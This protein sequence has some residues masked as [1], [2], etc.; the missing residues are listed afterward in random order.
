MKNKD[1]FDSFEKADAYYNNVCVP[2]FGATRL[3]WGF[4]KWLWLEHYDNLSL[5]WGEMYKAGILTAKGKKDYDRYI[6]HQGEKM[7]YRMQ[8]QME[9]E[10]ER[11]VEDEEE[12][13][14]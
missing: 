3:P 2:R 8:E 12:V 14:G 11:E 10:N 7:E 9:S 6:I 4:G 1:R 5:E 13:E